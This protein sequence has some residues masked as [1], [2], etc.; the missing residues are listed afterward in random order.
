[1]PAGPSR[2]LAFVHHR[3]SGKVE[4]RRTEDFSRQAKTPLTPRSR[5]LHF[6]A[7]DYS[8]ICQCTDPGRHEFSSAVASYSKHLAAELTWY[9]LRRQLEESSIADFNIYRARQQTELALEGVNVT[10]F[11]FATKQKDVVC[12]C[13]ESHHGQGPV[14]NPQI[15]ELCVGFFRRFNNKTTCTKAQWRGDID[16]FPGTI[17]PSSGSSKYDSRSMHDLLHQHQR[18]RQ[19]FD[20]EPLPD[21]THLRSGPHGEPDIP[22]QVWTYARPSRWTIRDDPAT[23][24]STPLGTAVMPQFP[25]ATVAST[26][27][28]VR[29]ASQHLYRRASVETIWSTVQQD[30]TGQAPEVLSEC[31]IEP[32]NIRPINRSGTSSSDEYGPRAA[33][34]LSPRVANNVARGDGI[35]ES[36]DSW[37]SG[38]FGTC[39][40]ELP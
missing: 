10:H 6:T 38:V 15:V 19:V 1:M 9:F 32:V 21:M 22:E 35:S 40:S 33:A 13:V 34:A 11:H 26:I 25:V 30:A 20:V 8:Q 16:Q 5:Y 3:K 29:P 31:L 28:T 18:E 37:G 17:S 7:E 36:P 23:S 14:Q 24:S 27:E 39:L 4:V 12:R 2:S